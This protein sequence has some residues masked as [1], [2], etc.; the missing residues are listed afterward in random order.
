MNCLLI[1]TIL[2]TVNAVA[3]KTINPIIG[4]NEMEIAL[5]N[6]VDINRGLLSGGRDALGGQFNY[7]WS[8][9]KYTKPGLGILMAA[10]YG[11]RYKLRSDVFAYAV[12]YADIIQFIGKRQKWSVGTQVGHSIYNREYKYEDLNGKWVHKYSGGIYYS[13]SVNYRAIIS[14]EILINISPYCAVKNIRRRTVTE[15]YYP[16]NGQE[17]NRKEEYSGVGLRLG[18]VL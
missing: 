14:E 16:S 15:Y 2:F 1:L 7:R 6:F 10:D 12:V 13:F 18:I 4:K 8:W 3:Q 9:K 11:K 5:F 17:T